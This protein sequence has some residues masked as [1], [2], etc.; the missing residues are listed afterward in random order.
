MEKWNPTQ[1]AI[2]KALRPNKFRKWINTFLI[3]LIGAG[4]IFLVLLFGSKKSSDIPPLEKST[5]INEGNL[6]GNTTQKIE[7]SSTRRDEVVVEDNS[8]YIN[9]SIINS[10]DYTNI[11]VT[12]L[13]ESGNI[14]SSIS[15]SIA[16][17]YSQT[18][19]KG[20]T[21]LFKS[22]FIHTSD[23]QELFNGN[24]EIIKKLRLS[25]HADYVVLGRISFSTNKGTL[26]EGTFVSEASIAI[27]I[28]SAK[29]QSIARSFS[30]SSKGNGV[31][32]KQATDN[33]LQ[34]L[35]DKFRDNYSSI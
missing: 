12:V 18:G 19:K 35:L 31:S 13:D 6:V 16:D 8:S 32:E 4:V 30:F 34:K 26:V 7:K 1:D 27:S 23:F 2:N 20:N 33:A 3:L 15:S 11:A 17:I 28:I 24:S 9:T 21:G 14:S 25:N 10:S 22:S 29:Q 5:T